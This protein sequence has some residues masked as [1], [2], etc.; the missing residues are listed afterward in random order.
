MYKK[1]CYYM[2][3]GFLFTIIIGTFMHFAYEWSGDSF[4]VGLIAPVNEST[5]EHMKLIFF[6][7]L[8]Y[9]IFSIYKLKDFYPCIATGMSAGL[10]LGTFLI[11]VLFYT[12]TGILGF[13]IL[14]MDIAVFVLSVLIAFIISYYLT[15]TCCFRNYKFFLL[16]FTFILMLSFFLFTV[17]P[18][19]IGIFQ[20]P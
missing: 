19:Q 7:M 10:L 6:P 9:S 4:L 14:W 13:H 15:K 1:L 5:W 2:I 20:I 3:F 11:P 8:F 17:F 12:Y 16:F 18:P